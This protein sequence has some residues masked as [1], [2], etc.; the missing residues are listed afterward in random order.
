MQKFLTWTFLVTLSVLSTM[1]PALAGQKTLAIVTRTD[2]PLVADLILL[3]DGNDDITGMKVTTNDGLVINMRPS[4]MR[5]RGKVLNSK[6]G[7]DV[8]ILRARNLDLQQG[9]T[10]VLDY[11]KEY[12][13]IGS[14]VRRN[15]E[16]EVV[17]GKNGWE[18]L[19][20]GRTVR[21]LKAHVTS[22]GI[23]RFTVK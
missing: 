13:L 20:Q 21:E 16:L 7:I 6:M 3:T 4:D 10:F 9:G 8:L 11:L 19:Y 2:G 15:L 22:S 12:K 18:I 17:R 23:D 5:G 1:A 14:N